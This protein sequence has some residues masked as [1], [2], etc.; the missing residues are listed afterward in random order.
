MKANSAGSVMK[1]P[2]LQLLKSDLSNYADWADIIESHMRAKDCWGAVAPEDEE[3][4]QMAALRL[5]AAGTD[6]TKIAKVGIAE[7]Q[8][9]N[10][11]V[12]ILKMSISTEL[13]TR[14][15][16]IKDAPTIWST[17]TPMRSVL[18]V[19]MLIETFNK[20]CLEDYTSTMEGVITLQGILHEVHAAENGA[21][22]LPEK[23]A[24]RQAITKLPTES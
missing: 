3:V 16:R 21:V 10:D 12:S 6:D 19:D 8:A 17:L 22:E 4:K 14:V 20:T 13:R 18:T 11:A 1:S 7:I 2:V 9:R 23:T 15:R 5:K 24:V